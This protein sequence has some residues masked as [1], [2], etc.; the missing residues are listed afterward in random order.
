MPPKKKQ[1]KEPQIEQTCD[2]CKR[3]IVSTRRGFTLHYIQDCTGPR[4]KVV[5]PT[6]AIDEIHGFEQF[7]KA[8][9]SFGPGKESLSEVESQINNRFSVE[10]TLKEKADH[11]C[12]KSPP[13][14]DTVFENTDDNY[15]EY[16][17]EST[18]CDH[19]GCP[20]VDVEA[21][22]EFE[23]NEDDP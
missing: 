4:T 19:H 6:Q 13:E 16:E 7:H 22:Y 8:A 23:D 12:C 11:A 5:I 15:F 1:R 14:N 9:T 20:I 10:Q 17:A 3:K 21:A 18:V 2:K